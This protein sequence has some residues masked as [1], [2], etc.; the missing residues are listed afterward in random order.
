MAV[1]GQKRLAAILAV[2]AI[3]LMW[4]VGPASAETLHILADYKAYPKCWRGLDGKP[5]G[6]M[7]D[8]LKNVTE[9]TGITFTYTMVPWKTAFEKSKNGEGAIIGLSKTTGRQEIWDY[10]SVMYS[11]PLVLVAWKDRPLPFT[12]LNSLQGK[13]IGIKLGASYGDDFNAAVQSGGFEVVQTHDRVGQLKM[14]ALGRLD[15]VLISPGSFALEP[16]FIEDPDLERMRERFAVVDPPLKLDPNYLGIPK[17]MGKTYLLEKIDAA[18]HAIR[19]DRT[20]EEIIANN[21]GKAK[22]ELWFGK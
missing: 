10:S 5:H 17:I 7:I 11:D 21:S 1:F 19:E 3:S 20:Y 2:L 16:L 9:R 18:L 15:A 13:K 6:I 14:L 22:R 12:G 8:I 4:R